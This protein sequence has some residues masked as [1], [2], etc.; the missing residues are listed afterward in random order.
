MNNLKIFVSTALIDNVNKPLSHYNQ[1]S[2]LSI[3]KRMKEYSECFNIIKSFGHEFTIVETFLS[4]SNFLEQYSKVLYTNVNNSNYKN[5]GS[6]YVNAFKKLMIMCDFKEDDLII[7]ITGRYPLI[8]D[9][10]IKRCVNL[11]IDEVGCFG[12]DINDQC[13]LFLYAM[14]YKQLNNL[15]NSISIDYLESSNISIERVFS[16][17]IKNYKIEIVEKLGIIGRQSSSS[18]DFYS[19][20]VY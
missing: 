16:D 14:R 8:D 2:D 4:Q 7:H 3:D 5:R 12:K 11:K 18:D 6:N 19:K 15:L 1:R 20:E 9:S 13:Y 10:F 17:K